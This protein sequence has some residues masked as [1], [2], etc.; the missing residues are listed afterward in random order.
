MATTVAT[1]AL[2]ERK[3]EWILVEERVQLVQGEEEGENQDVSSSLVKG[4]AG[5]L[6]RIVKPLNEEALKPTLNITH[7]W[8]PQFSPRK[9]FR[10]WKQIKPDKTKKR[11][12]MQYYSAYHSSTWHALFSSG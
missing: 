12:S 2:L 4:I 3:G 7:R 10:I 9:K 6:V 5:E 1:N 11:P 8:C